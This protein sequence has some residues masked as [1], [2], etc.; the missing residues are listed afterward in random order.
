MRVEDADPSEVQLLRVLPDLELVCGVAQN[1][2]P[3]RMKLQLP[4]M[5]GKKKRTYLYTAP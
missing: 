5:K 1:L 2:D 3:G 4:A